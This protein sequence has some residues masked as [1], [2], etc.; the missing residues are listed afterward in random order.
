MGADEAQAC[1]DIFLANGIYHM[2][3]CYREGL[4]FR[5]NPARSYRIGYARSLDLLNWKRDDS[6]MNLDVSENGWD[7]KMIAYPTV[8]ELDGSTYMIYAGNG[9]GQTGIGL[10]KLDGEL[11]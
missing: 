3:F 11:H 2:F 9:N 6:Q 1:P 10:A 7:S 4:D 5:D 8:F